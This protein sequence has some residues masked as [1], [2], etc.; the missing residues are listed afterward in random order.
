MTASAK[1]TSSYLEGIVEGRAF[2]RKHGL[3]VAR[4]EIE[5]LTA[6]IAGFSANSPVGQFL[7]G[8]RDFWRH[9]IKRGAAA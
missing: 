3:G 6:T 4:H 5:N 1:I 2:L 9:Q 8:E 7:R